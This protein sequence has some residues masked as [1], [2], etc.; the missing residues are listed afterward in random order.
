MKKLRKGDTVSVLSGKD[1]GRKGKVEQLLPKRGVVLVAGIN[2]Y[3]KHLKASVAADKK[4]GIYDLERPI[5]VSKV[6]LICPNCKKPTRV[7]FELKAKKKV[8]VCRKCGQV[9]D[10]GKK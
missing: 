2:I 5:A 10:G 8:R 3:K 6:A 4:G 9:I 1:K 7:G